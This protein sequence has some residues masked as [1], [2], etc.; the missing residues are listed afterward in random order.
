MEFNNEKVFYLEDIDFDREGHLTKDVS[1]PVLI[2]I[3]GSQCPHCHHAI[4]DFI[5]LSKM[6]PN[7]VLATIIT[8]GSSADSKLL[9]KLPSIIP[10]I[11][12]VPTFVL[13]RNGRYIKTHSG[14]RTAAALKKFAET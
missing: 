1:E 6:A 12:G 7:I 4:P 13:F 3:Y 14:E 2:M 10:N 11:Q 8:D 9:A 5:K